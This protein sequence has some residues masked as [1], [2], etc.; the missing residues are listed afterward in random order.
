[1]LNVYFWRLEM[2]NKFRT[3]ND[4]FHSY[5]IGFGGKWYTRKMPPIPE[6]ANVIFLPW[7]EL[8]LKYT[9]WKKVYEYNK[10][11]K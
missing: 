4:V 9:N 2:C 6:I 1:M 11:T 3:V 7:T 8:L 10:T 5:S